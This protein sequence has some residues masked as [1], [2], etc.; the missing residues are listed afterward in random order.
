ML[1]YYDPNKQLTLQVDSSG[2]GLGAAIIQDE[3]PIAFASKSLSDAESRYS[4]IEREMLSI[5]FRLERFHYF[6]YG[7]PVIVHSDHKPL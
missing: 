2:S 5:L 4:N 3:G 7:R 6:T 1:K